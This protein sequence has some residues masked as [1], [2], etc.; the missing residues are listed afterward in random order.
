MRH[1]PPRTQK[2]VQLI[3]E[4]FWNQR[5]GKPWTEAERRAEERYRKKQAAD[6]AELSKIVK[7]TKKEFR[8]WTWLGD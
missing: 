6:Q 8:P 3:G 7:R 5:T 4:G 2:P 1:R